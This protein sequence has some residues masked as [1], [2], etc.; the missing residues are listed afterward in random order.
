MIL[1]SDL[2]K[3]TEAELTQAL[4]QELMAAKEHSIKRCPFCTNALKRTTYD[5]DH[6]SR[7]WEILAELEGR[8]IMKEH[9]K[10]GKGKT[11]PPE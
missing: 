7:V 3:H 11:A 8:H 10:Y 4:A 1:L 5:I 6:G 9:Q 2:T